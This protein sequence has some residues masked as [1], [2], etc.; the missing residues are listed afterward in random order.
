MLKP[1]FSWGASSLGAPP[2]LAVVWFDPPP[3]CR[4]LL[5]NTT[6]RRSAGVNPRG[7]FPPGGNCSARKVA[8]LR[9]G[10]PHWGLPSGI[11]RATHVKWCG[12]PIRG[13]WY[14]PAPVSPGAPVTPLVSTRCCFPPR[15]PLFR[16][17]PQNHGEP[18]E[19][20]PRGREWFLSNPR[21]ERTQGEEFQGGS[22]F[23]KSCSKKSFLAFPT[24]TGRGTLPPHLIGEFFC[25]GSRGIPLGK[26]GI[27]F[28]NQKGNPPRQGRAQTLPGN[29]NCPLK[30]VANPQFHKGQIKGFTFGPV[31]NYRKEGRVGPGKPKG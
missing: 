21:G 24:K 9:R 26:E 28:S 27:P 1:P 13:V 5:G 3:V 29:S 22:P 14:F 20:F 7:L 6:R 25:W 16:W 10:G 15:S 4:T 23:Q 30:M 18:N 8:P 31:L 12:T 19:A 11:R 17:G 2:L